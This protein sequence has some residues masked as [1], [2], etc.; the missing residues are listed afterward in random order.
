MSPVAVIL[1]V[2]TLIVTGWQLMRFW[3]AA[4]LGRQNGLLGLAFVGLLLALTGTAAYRLNPVWRNSLVG[5]GL[6]LLW[7]Y[8]LPLTGASIKALWTE[9]IWPDDCLQELLPPL[10][11]LSTSLDFG[12]RLFRGW[13]SAK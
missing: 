3:L 2:A 10:M 12:W 8:Y 9:P 5:C 4:G 7:I 1:T 13:A 11:V 6:A